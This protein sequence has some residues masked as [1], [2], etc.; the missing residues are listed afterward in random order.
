ME[1]LIKEFFWGYLE[2]NFLDFIIKL[3]N[4]LINFFFGLASI[5]DIGDV[6]RSGGEEENEN[7]NEWHDRKPLKMV[8][9]NHSNEE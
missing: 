6:T 3:F 9:L 2:V 4:I 8:D 7:Q 5:F 1:A